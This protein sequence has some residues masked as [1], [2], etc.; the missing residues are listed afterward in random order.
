MIVPKKAAAPLASD[1]AAP[2][3]RAESSFFKNGLRMS[4]YTPQA[5]TPMSIRGTID[6][7]GFIKNGDRIE[8]GA[9]TAL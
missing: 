3:A 4:V 6:T 8:P 7:S 2:C 1:V 9:V 5:T